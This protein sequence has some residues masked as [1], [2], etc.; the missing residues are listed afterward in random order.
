VSRDEYFLKGL[1][2]LSVH[3]L[4]R[5]FTIFGFLIDNKVELKI[6]KL[7]TNFENPSSN[8]KAVI[9]SLAQEGSV[10]AFHFFI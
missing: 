2:V 6:L 10:L 5:V 7:L 3:A 4:M 8:P 1:K 9:L